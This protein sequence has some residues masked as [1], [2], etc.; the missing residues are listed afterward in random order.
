MP[1]GSKI[2]VEGV[3]TTR[4]MS[5]HY[6]R[7]KQAYKNFN[8]VSPS[9]VFDI[10]TSGISSRSGGRETVKAAMRSSGRSNCVDLEFSVM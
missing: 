8:V 7:M 9:Q 5:M 4:N 3:M 1:R 10:D 6:A 2:I